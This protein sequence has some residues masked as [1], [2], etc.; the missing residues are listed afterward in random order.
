MKNVY[1][2]KHRL[3]FDGKVYTTHA[4][5]GWCK[6]K[7]EA[8]KQAKQLSPLYYTRVVARKAAPFGYDVYT[9]PRGEK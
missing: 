7:K 8:Q 2:M 1:E 5:L 6:T 3:K 4:V 9:R